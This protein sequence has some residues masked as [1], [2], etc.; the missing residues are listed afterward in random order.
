MYFRTNQDLIQ[1]VIA[2][3]FSIAVALIGVELSLRYL[4]VRRNLIPAIMSGVS[5]DR[6]LPLEVITEE[7]AKG[8]PLYPRIAPTWVSLQRFV[9]GNERIVTFGNIAGTEVVDCNESGNYS[10]S[11]M[12]EYGFRNPT[13]IWETKEDPTIMIVGDSF[14]YG[15][16]VPDG[17]DVA[18]NLRKEFPRTITL[19]QG[20]NGPLLEL[21]ALSEYALPARPKV[22]IWMFYE[23]N[24]FYNLREERQDEL[25]LRYLEDDFSQRLINRHTEIQDFLKGQVNQ[26]LAGHKPAVNRWVSERYAFKSVLT[27][28]KLR[29]IVSKLFSRSESSIEPAES[30]WDLLGRVMRIAKSRTEEAGAQFLLVSI[31]SWPQLAEGSD[32]RVPR[33]KLINLYQS[34]GIDYLDIEHLFREN[35]DWPRFYPFRNYGHW[36]EEGY[37]FVAQAILKRIVLQ[38]GP[39]LSPPQAKK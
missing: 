39:I 10:I 1:N 19:G 34:L 36:N 20:G 11:K 2:F 37:R 7:R 28:F 14:A 16:C 26:L 30:E 6:R 38:N 32:P 4:E 31:P 35:Q 27:L 21:G 24:D 5:Y 18:S 17:I 33:D 12:D 23:G 3:L 8:R 9:S 25:L 13:G 22:V 15:S 29:T